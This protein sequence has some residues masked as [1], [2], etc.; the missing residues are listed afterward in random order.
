MKD[1]LTPEEMMAAVENVQAGTE[2]GERRRV[3]PYFEPWKVLHLKKRMTQEGAARFI[4]K[5]NSWPT[6]DASVASVKSTFCQMLSRE[7]RTN[8][9]TKKEKK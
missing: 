1:Q 2:M 9:K 8:E 5:Q 7:N 3:A 4:S 6:D